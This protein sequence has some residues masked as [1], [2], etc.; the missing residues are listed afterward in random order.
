MPAQDPSEPIV[1]TARFLPGD[2]QAAAAAQA[3][4]INP[5]NAPN[6]A[7]MAAALPDF[8][9]EPAAIVAMTQKYWGPGGVKLTVG[10]LDNAETALRS[11]IL[12]HMNAWGK[13]AN[14]EFTETGDST[15]ARVRIARVHGGQQGGYWSYIGTD[16]DQIAPGLPTMNLDSFTADT[17]DDE[18]TR[19]VRHETGHTLGFPHEHLRQEIVARIVRERAYAYFGGYP[20]YWKPA[21][22]DKNV[23]T[24]LQQSL[25]ILGTEKPDDMSIMTYQL[26]GWIMSDLKPVVGGR[27]IDPA[28]YA[29]AGL[30]YPKG[31]GAATTLVSGSPDAGAPGTPAAGV[32]AAPLSMEDFIEVATRAS[33]RVLESQARPSQPAGTAATAGRG[34]IFVGIVASEE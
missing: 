28:D 15:H 13:T 20:N 27:D 33:L 22:V 23:L 1:C 32:T 31:D 6:L 21:T 12:L 18:F 24:P 19:V 5:A 16:I 7:A 2:Q 26:P 17:S 14:V 3:I 9:P 30:L 4:K 29:F 10:F 8:T 11:K 34:R 25:L